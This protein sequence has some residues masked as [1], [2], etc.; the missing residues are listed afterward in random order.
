MK[1]IGKYVVLMFAG[2]GTAYWASL[3]VEK[4]VDGKVAIF[5]IAPA[6]I[7]SISYKSEDIKV[8]LEKQSGGTKYWVNYEKAH[9]VKEKEKS[10]P[11]DAK[12]KKDIKEEV[13]VKKEIKKQRFLTSEKIDEILEGLNPFEALRVV[14]EK[15]DAKQLEEFGLDKPKEQVTFKD[16]KGNSHTFE[17][18]SK[19]YGS[20]NKF[21]IEKKSGRVLLVDGKPFESLSRANYRLY[22]RKILS[23][24][25]DDV[26]DAT[27]SVA[28][29]SKK[30]E[31][32][33]R[34]SKGE[35]QWADKKEGSKPKSSYKSWM[36]KISRL[37]I[38]KF[39]DEEMT[40]K[41]IATVPYL[42][43]TF[44]RKGSKLDRMGFYKM[45]GEKKPTYWVKS[46]FLGAFAE[47]SSNRIGPIEKDIDSIM[48]K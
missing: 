9:V 22:E 48:N 36:N 1:E 42:H 11:K 20:R 15:F 37:K 4:G 24:N 6:S 45:K 16:K 32:T 46:E 10:K 27:L 18:G 26:T 41:L 30:L 44:D 23:F 35:L 13:A 28:R 47:V 5:S 19:S 25:F 14:G 34:N 31:H 8:S 2:L 12:K 33:Q 40:A 7:A 39:A 21:V 17:I 38:K 29:T 43:I 3:P